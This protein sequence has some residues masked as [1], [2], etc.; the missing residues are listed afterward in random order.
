MPVCPVCVT[1]TRSSPARGVHL[2]DFAKASASPELSEL[3]SRYIFMGNLG[4]S[5][6]WIMRLLPPSYRMFQPPATLY[7]GMI[8]VAEATPTVILGED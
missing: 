3:T 7:D 4:E 5:Y 1:A 6:A 8:I 2:L